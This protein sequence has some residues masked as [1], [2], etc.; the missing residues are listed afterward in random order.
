MLRLWRMAMSKLKKKISFIIPRIY[1]LPQ[2]IF[3]RWL[4]NE[5]FIPKNNFDW[6]IK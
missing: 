3:I 1:N 6:W 5:Y 4:D 2:V